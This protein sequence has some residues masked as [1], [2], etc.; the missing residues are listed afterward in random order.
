LVGGDAI[1][2]V[3]VGVEAIIVEE[4]VVIIAVEEEAMV[5]VVANLVADTVGADMVI[6]EVI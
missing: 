3:V 5:W 2:I 6:R 1:L 4:A